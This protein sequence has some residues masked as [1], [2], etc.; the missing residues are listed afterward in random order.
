M[1][2]TSKEA[3]KMLHELETELNHLLSEED[4]AKSFLAAVGEDIESCRPKY[5][6]EETQLAINSVDNKII[7][8]KHSIN[9]FNTETIV[10]GFNKTIDEMLIYI[11]QLTQ[12]SHKLNIMQ[13]KLPKTREALNM[14]STIIDYRY[15]NY[16]IDK[17]KQDYKA[18]VDE[19]HRAQ[20]ALDTVNVTKQFEVNI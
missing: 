3:N 18:T 8:L 15:V 7:K 6:Y 14:R 19:L 4:Q 2:V 9:K 16:D 1:L 13:N 12:R 10:D 17:V 11:P 20:I 5:N